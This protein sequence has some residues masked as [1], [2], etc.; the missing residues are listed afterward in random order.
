MYESPFNNN[1]NNNN[2]KWP[3]SGNLGN[4]NISAARGIR[5]APKETKEKNNWKSLGMKRA[6]GAKDA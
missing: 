1:K 2:V 5:N 3:Y 4:T 6:K